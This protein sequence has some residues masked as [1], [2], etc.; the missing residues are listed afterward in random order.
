MPPRIKN[1]GK[2]GQ[3]K[4]GRKTILRGRHSQSWEMTYASYGNPQSKQEK[5]MSIVGKGG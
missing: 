5:A 1:A 3:R 2:G 4:T